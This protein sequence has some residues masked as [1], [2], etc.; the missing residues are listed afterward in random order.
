VVTTALLRL[1]YSAARAE[2]SDWDDYRRC[3]ADVLGG[4]Y[5]DTLEQ[6]REAYGPYED[7]TIFFGVR[8]PDGRV[9]GFC[10]VIAPGP[11]GLKTITDVG[12][13]PWSIDGRR[14]AAAAGIDLSRTLDVTT[15]GV[16]RRLG[17]A[18]QIVAAALY[19][20]VI[21][22]ARINSYPWIV[23]IGDTRVRSLLA[24]VGLVLHALPGTAPAE[25]M[26]SQACA[27]VYANIAAM[28]DH[29]RRTAHDAYRLIALGI[30]LDGIAVPPP[31]GFRLCEWPPDGPGVDLSA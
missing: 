17:G 6:L 12:L 7:H 18:G 27:P 15:L 23:A 14:S 4:W 29:Q 25:Y 21:N 13:A 26:G 20:A 10:R 5:G 19:Y 8:R 22:T 24:S 16:D 9:V 28:L 11:L 2:S 30:G 1:E 31:E 3:E